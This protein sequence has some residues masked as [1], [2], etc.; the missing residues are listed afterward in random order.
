MG[1]NRQLGFVALA[2]TVFCFGTLW[3]AAK[4]SIDYISPLWFTAGR[5]AIGA[6]FVTFLLMLQGRM[7][8]PDRADL[9]IILSVGGIMLGLYSSIFQNALEFVHAGRAT[10]LGYTTTIFVTFLIADGL[11][12][13][14]FGQVSGRFPKANM[15]AP[16]KGGWERFGATYS[17]D[18]NEYVLWD[19]REQKLVRA[20]SVR[21]KP[22]ADRWDKESLMAIQARGWSPRSV[23]DCLRF[24]TNYMFVT[25][26]DFS[27]FT[28]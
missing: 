4:F 17:R 25:F 7:R 16:W 28:K 14:G 10:I 20:R 1:E 13:E 9:P 19:V 2:T 6:V 15:G 24:R 5:F 23:G 26:R 22:E 18:S 8:L 3:T 27:V 11:V 21:R 12:L